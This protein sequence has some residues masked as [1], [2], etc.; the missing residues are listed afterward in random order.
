MPVSQKLGG[1]DTGTRL[2]GASRIGYKYSETVF[3]P[4]EVRSLAADTPT[5]VP[6]PGAGFTNV[7][8][9][10]FL[11]IQA[12]SGGT[13]HDDAAA[14]GDLVVNYTNAAG[15]AVST[16]LDADTFIDTAAGT[17]QLRTLKQITTD[18]TPVTNAA[19]VLDND[20]AEFT[21]TGTFELRVVVIY[22]TVPTF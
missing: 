8:V 20:G 3:S 4:G 2:G 7:F 19:L 15:A 10:A 5:L 9:E 18:V 14:D 22:Y 17:D 12:P 1:I 21:G 11:S 6:A 16:T 13:A